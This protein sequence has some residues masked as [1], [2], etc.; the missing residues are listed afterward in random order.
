MPAVPPKLP[1]I[2]NGGWAS[3]RFGYVPPPL[4]SRLARRIDVL[5]VRPQ[6]PVGV[7]AVEQPRPEVDLPGLAPAGAAVAAQLERPP[8]GRGEVRRVERVDLVAGIQPDE[9]RHVAVLRVLVVPVAI[10]LLQ[11]AAAADLVGRQPVQR[12]LDPA[13]EL[14]VDAQRV[15][16]P[17]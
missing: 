16:A 14:S 15:R 8:H 17:A 13:A 2:W 1:S 5:Q 7:V 9:V 10:P 6:H 11:V 3:K 4:Y 12:R